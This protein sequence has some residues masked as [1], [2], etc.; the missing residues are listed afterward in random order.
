MEVSY[1]AAYEKACVVIGDLTVRLRLTEEQ[2]EAAH[3]LIKQLVPADETSA[4]DEV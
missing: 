3:A 2:L 1:E 4:P